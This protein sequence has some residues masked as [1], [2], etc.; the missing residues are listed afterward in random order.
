MHIW[1]TAGQEKYQSLT[2]RFFKDAQAIIFAFSV[3]DDK[4]FHNLDSWLDKVENETQESNYVKVIVGNKCDKETKSISYQKASSYAKD[5]KAIYYETSAKDGT[6]ITEVFQTIAN[7]LFT[8]QQTGGFNKKAEDNKKIKKS[9]KGK[10][11]HHKKKG[12]C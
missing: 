1:D 5:N 4:S 3:D 8:M 7:K 6:N 9:K 2:S 10:G 11:K 12:C